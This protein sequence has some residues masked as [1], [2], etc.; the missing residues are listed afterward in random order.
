VALRTS[1]TGSPLFVA[2][3]FAAQGIIYN[4]KPFRSKDCPYVDVLRSR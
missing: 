2:I 1:E 4:V 3:T